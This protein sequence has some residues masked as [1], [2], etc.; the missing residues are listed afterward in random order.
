MD[1]S[2]KSKEQLIEEL[3]RAQA[4]IEFLQSSAGDE[5][6]FRQLID[7]SPVPYAINDEQQ[8]IT[9]LNPAFIKTFGYDLDD[10]PTLSDWWPRAYPDPEYRQWVAKVWAEQ[11]QEAR[12]L[13][14]PFQA[15]ELC[16]RCKDGSD[17]FVKCSAV[18]LTQDYVGDHLV[19]LVDITEHKRFERQ[20]KEQ[21]QDLIEIFDHLPS[22]IFLKDAK[23][24]RYVRFNRAGERLTG[25]SRE[26]IIGR[27]DFD[28]FPKEQA[29]F[30][31]GRDRV[32]LAS[33]ELEDIPD[34]PIAT[35]QGTRRL[36]TRKVSIRDENG[37]AKYLLGVS[38]DIT[39][40]MEIAAE[41]ERLQRELQQAH[42]MESLGQLTGGIAHDFNNLLGIISGFTELALG[43]AENRA[44]DKIVDYL[45]Q[46]QSAEKRATH[47]VSQ[48]LAFSRVDKTE[49]NLVDLV[50]LIEDDIK[51]L[52]ATLPSSIEI[53]SEIEPELPP[54]II[55]PVQI[56]QILM[57]LAVN[58]RDAMSGVGKLTIKLAWAKDVNLEATVSHKAIS[59]DWVELSVSDTGC[60]IPKN[61]IEDI[62]TP[63]YT[64]KPVGKGTGMGLSVIYGIMK[65][66]NGHI[67]VESEPGKGSTFR[68]LFPPVTGANLTSVADKELEKAPCGR[69]EEILVVDDEIS[70]AGYIGELLHG[71]GYQPV[72]VTDSVEAFNMYKE[73][74][75]RFAV[76]VTDQTM[77]SLT[78]MDLLEQVR[79]IS[80]LQKIIICSGYS[81]TLDKS[82]LGENLAFFQKPIDARSLLFEVHQLLQAGA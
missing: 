78:G 50:P 10:I 76:I 82:R 13:H 72:V 33:G 75:G 59:G 42:K 60:G 63:F 46:V 38:D 61:T 3:N 55:N 8:N 81:D 52:R 58:G 27:N 45:K 21:E 1:H 15:M 9:Y 30:F 62:F 6:K 26:D 4:R 68:L 16:I 48:M 2:A 18:P 80:P 20:L 79:E 73:N 12:R 65:N 11:L 64:S 35:P 56:N 37:N 71:N 57:N 49:A 25:I 47:L 77:P 53:V 39:E 66:C 5:N 31:T 36:H 23:D 74:P 41:R 24:L 69:G 44:M 43:L 28:F 54:V 34:E 67:L 40:Q 29:E 70:L 14:E 22:M 51:M 19:I 32:V 17:R 7:A